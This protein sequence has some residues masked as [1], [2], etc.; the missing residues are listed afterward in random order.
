MFY[1]VRKKTDYQKNTMHKKKENKKWNMKKNNEKRIIC[2][3]V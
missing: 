2:K 3:N 1:A